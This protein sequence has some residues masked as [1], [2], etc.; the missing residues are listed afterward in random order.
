MGKAVPKGVKRK[1]ALLMGEFPKE[2]GEFEKNKSFLASLKIPFDK[3]TRN[4]VAG[5]I[6]REK[7]KAREKLAVEEAAKKKALEAALAPK[8][9]P[10]TGMGVPKALAEPAPAEQTSTL[11]GA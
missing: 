9:K 3:I 2:F 10:V 6:A 1:A 8:P 4:L 5:F 7:R 11:T